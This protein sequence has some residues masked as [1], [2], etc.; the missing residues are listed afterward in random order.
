MNK[1]LS[2]IGFTSVLLLSGCAVTPYNP[3]YNSSTYIQSGTVGYNNY[4]VRDRY[5][6][7][8]YDPIYN[9]YGYGYSPSIILRYDNYDRNRPNWNRPNRPNWN[10]NGG[11]RPNRPDRPHHA[12]N[13]PRN[14]DNR[15][16]RPHR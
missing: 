2:L 15:P 1:Y 6:G 10:H 14:N 13:T 11:T 12:P 3:G 16:D 5:Y 4:S 9:N 8:S 7:S